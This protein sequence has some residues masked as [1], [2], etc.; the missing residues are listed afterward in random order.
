MD[1][2]LETAECAI[3]DGML[4]SYSR[5]HQLQLAHDTSLC[6]DVFGPHNGNDLGVYW[7]HGAATV[8]PEASSP[9][10]ALSLASRE[11]HA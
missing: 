1:M 10:H 3:T 9:A 11:F 5:S 2:L 8:M 4:W 6:L 7:C